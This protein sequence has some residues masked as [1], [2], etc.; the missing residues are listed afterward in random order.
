MMKEETIMAEDNSKDTTVNKKTISGKSGKK[1]VIML[2]ASANNAGAPVNKGTSSVKETERLH[3]EVGDVVKMKKPHPC[4]SSEWE[5]LRV[6]SDFK[7]KCL[8]CSHVVMVPRRQV[9]K[10]TR[11]LTKSNTDK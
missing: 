1:T 2:G 8:G 4:G 9:E 10:N 7:M 11:K 3:F 6:G 5:L